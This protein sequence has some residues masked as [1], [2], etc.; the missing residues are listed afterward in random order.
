MQFNW[1]TRPEFLLLDDVDLFGAFSN[2]GNESRRKAR[3]RLFRCVHEEWGILAL[4]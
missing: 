2:T 3:N 4:H 1:V